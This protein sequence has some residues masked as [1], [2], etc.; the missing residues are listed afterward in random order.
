MSCSRMR[1]GHA[2]TVAGV[3]AERSRPGDLAG[4]ALVEPTGQNKVN[5]VK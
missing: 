1:S 5:K 2:G 4:P 3:V